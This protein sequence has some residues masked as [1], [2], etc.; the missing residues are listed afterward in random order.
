YPKVD[1]LSIVLSTLGF[2]GLLYGFSSVGNYGWGHLGVLISL[3]VGAICLTAFIWRQLKLKQP[4]LEFRVFTSRTF[5]FTTIIGMTT[6]MMLIAAETI[7]PIYMQIMAGFSAL[8]SGMMMLPGALLM[9]I[10]SPFVGRIFD[11]IG[12]RWL[13]I[14]GLF[15]MTVTTIFYTNLTEN[16]S[17]MYLTVVFAIRMIGIA[18]VSMPATTAGLNRSE[19]RRVG[20]AARRWGGDCQYEG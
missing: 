11:K 17:F 5:T 6:F 9:G 13:L 14:I 7:L 20:Q 4:L 3:I 12:A 16:T 8:E 2:G 18:M 10:L 19:E 1:Y 15:I